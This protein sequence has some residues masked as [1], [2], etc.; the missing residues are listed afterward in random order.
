MLHLLGVD[1]EDPGGRCA[2]HSDVAARIHQPG[3]LG[4]GGGET[5]IAHSPVM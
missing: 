2:G 4:G 3:V 1:V 5:A